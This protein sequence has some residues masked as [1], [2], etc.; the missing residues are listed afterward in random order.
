[1]ATRPVAAAALSAALLAACAG[2]SAEDDRPAAPQPSTVT[3]LEV[4]LQVQVP[5]QLADLTYT[6]GEAEEGQ[7]ALYFSTEQLASVGGPSCAA[8]AEAAVSPYPLGQVVV[9][10]ETPKHVREEAKANPEE[11]LGRFVK[12]VGDRYLYYVSPPTESCAGDRNAA[13]LQRDLTV[14]LRSA[15]ETLRAAP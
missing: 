5:A 10:E 4:D 3:F 6:L 1:M 8:G 11:N 14:E 13:R 15:L 2:C 12:Q 7:P 9:S